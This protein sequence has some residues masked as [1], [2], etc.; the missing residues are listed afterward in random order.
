M[1]SL[2]RWFLA[3]LLGASLLAGEGLGE[4]PAQ[5]EA[6]PR[7]SAQRYGEGGEE[8]G[9]AFSAAV[10]PVRF[11]KGNPEWDTQELVSN[12]MKALHEEHRQILR[13]LRELKSRMARLEEGR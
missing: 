13:E 7:A 2:G 10:D 8:A 11:R 3:L 9:D 12:G 6:P 4:R 5:E 1:R